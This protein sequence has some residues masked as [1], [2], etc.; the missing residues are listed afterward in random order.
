MSIHDFMRNH[1]RRCDI[2]ADVYADICNAQSHVVDCTCYVTLKM[3][4]IVKV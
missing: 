3:S 4:V 2:Q 1:R